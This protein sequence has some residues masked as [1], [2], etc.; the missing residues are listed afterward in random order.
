MKVMSRCVP[1]CWR[2]CSL[3]VITCGFD[4]GCNLNAI[5]NTAVG[6]CSCGR[7]RYVIESSV[8]A[9]GRINLS[10]KEVRAKAHTHIPK[11][12]RRSWMETAQFVQLGF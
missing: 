6:N 1:S 3:T 9:S 8:K 4:S 12:R 2:L 10:E 7:G 11:I 5:I